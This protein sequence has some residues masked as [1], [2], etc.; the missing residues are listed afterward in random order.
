M[1]DGSPSG[2]SSRARA[3]A[4]GGGRGS[5]P[6]DR[7]GHNGGDLTEE[8]AMP[9]TTNPGLA[10][11]TETT[12]GL[13]PDPLAEPPPDTVSVHDA[14]VHTFEDVVVLRRAVDRMTPTRAVEHASVIHTTDAS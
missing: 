12:S 6:S 11:G 5:R 2:W 9:T 13:D 1:P 14:P 7:R 3:P 4:R 10:P 8:R